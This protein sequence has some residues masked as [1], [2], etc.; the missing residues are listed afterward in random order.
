MIGQTLSHDRI[1][2]KI[3][4]GGMGVVYR[5]HDEQLD[6]DVA[7]KVLP[8]GTPADEAARKQFRKEA[9]ALAKLNHPNI[10]TVFEFGSQ[11]GLD[12]LAMGLI[13]GHTLSEELKDGPLMETEIVRL[14][15][16]FAEGLAAAHEQGVIH[17]DLKPGNLMITPGG[18]LK[19]LDFGLAR[20]IPVMADPDA[21][22][23]LTQETGFISGTIPYMPPEQLRGEKTDARADV[24]SAGAVLYDMA[25]PTWECGSWQTFPYPASWTECGIDQA[26]PIDLSLAH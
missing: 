21:T 12:F 4:A 25:N 1:V 20:L 10:E 24:Y 5:A 3:G 11:D 17:R 22:R 13:S 6:R 16:Q 9:L 2:E 19:I 23:S 15:I 8:A 7:L 18:R 14:G 26:A